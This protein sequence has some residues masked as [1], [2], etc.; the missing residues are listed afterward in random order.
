MYSLVKIWSV[1]IVTVDR[2]IWSC[3]I[4]CIALAKSFAM[5]FLFCFCFFFYFFHISCSLCIRRYEHLIF[6]Q[7]RLDRFEVIL[8]TPGRIILLNFR[9][10]F[11]AVHRHWRMSLQWGCQVLISSVTCCL[12]ED[13]VFGLLKVSSAGVMILQPSNRI[14]LISWSNI[15]S[16]VWVVPLSK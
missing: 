11:L 9:L 16:L 14:G 6:D 13:I 5:F 3:I 10:L 8:V 12:G 15:K 2:F 1:Q 4:W 7:C